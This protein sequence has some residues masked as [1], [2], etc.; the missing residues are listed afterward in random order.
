MHTPIDLCSRH[1]ER[2]TREAFVAAAA[3]T[4]FGIRVLLS[5]W[6]WRNKLLFR[7]GPT[8]VLAS[9]NSKFR[10]VILALVMVRTYWGKV[11]YTSLFG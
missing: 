5:H 3:D 6:P 2:L 10:C 8:Q 7:P 11:G 9:C 4:T 1:Y